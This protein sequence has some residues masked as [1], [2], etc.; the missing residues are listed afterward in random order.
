MRIDELDSNQYEL[1]KK[2]DTIPQELIN[3][4]PNL[5][6]ESNLDEIYDD[7]TK[8]E[9]ENILNIKKTEFMSM[10]SKLSDEL[11]KINKYPYIQSE[12]NK[13]E[14]SQVY[15]FITALTYFVLMFYF[16]SIFVL[17]TIPIMLYIFDKLN[18][19]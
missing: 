16:R 9:R 5:I 8:L 19:I 1:Y 15:I 12:I 13:Y 18:L 14:S 6:D 2:T 10:A 7:Y 4:V 17:L 11:D 3:D